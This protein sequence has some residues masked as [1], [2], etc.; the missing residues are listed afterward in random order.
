MG[1][2]R[3]CTFNFAL[4]WEIKD[5]E[6]AEAATL[7]LTL[8]VAG[9]MITVLLSGLQTH[10]ASHHRL[11]FA[12]LTVA[13]E[14]VGFSQPVVA[15]LCGVQKVNVADEDL[16]TEN[17]AQHVGKKKSFF[18][19]FLPVSFG[20]IYNRLQLLKLFISVSYF[21]FSNFFNTSHSVYG[22]LD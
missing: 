4:S 21:T 1:S 11:A 8:A 12:F 2:L 3:L 6:K 10:S 5:D 18:F 14:E 16:E 9:T 7:T 19:I 17:N 13:G 20:P 15:I 22:S